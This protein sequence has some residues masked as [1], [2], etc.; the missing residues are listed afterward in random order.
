MSK[1]TPEEREEFKQRMKER[2][3]NKCGPWQEAAK[4]KGEEEKTN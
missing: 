2:W 1:M 4:K 3:G